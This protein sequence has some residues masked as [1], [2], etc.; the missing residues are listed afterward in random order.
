MMT[1]L[2]IRNV[3]EAE[4]PDVHS[5]NEESVPAMNSLPLEKFAWFR[6]QAPYFRVAAVAGQIAGFLIC[7]KPATAYDSPNFRWM[8]ERYKDFFYIDRIAVGK[9]FQRLGLGRA[10]YD[11]AAAVASG[12]YSLLACEVNLRPRNQGSLDFHDSYGFEAVGSQD[13]GYARVQF[14][15]KRL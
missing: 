14:M 12:G 15:V 11:D 2:E 13:N 9:K 3:T 6:E 5:I 4:L 8:N 10:L 7:L 1:A